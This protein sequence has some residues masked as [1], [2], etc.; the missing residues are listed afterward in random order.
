MKKNNK[1]RFCSKCGG[2]ILRNSN[3]TVEGVIPVSLWEKFAEISNRLCL[4]IKRADSIFDF[5]RNEQGD[6][7]ALAE[8][9]LKS[10]NHFCCED[11]VKYMLDLG[12]VLSRKALCLESCIKNLDTTIKCL[13][14]AIKKGILRM[15]LVC[16]AATI[17]IVKFDSNGVNNLIKEGLSHIKETS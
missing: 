8:Y 17:K 6:V 13:S 14:D 7:F 10:M 15:M 3:S 9:G 11:C 5:E 12:R 1:V 16:M 4:K 2:N